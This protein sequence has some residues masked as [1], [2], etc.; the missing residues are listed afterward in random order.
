MRE[1]PFVFAACD[2]ALAGGA[3]SVVPGTKTSSGLALCQEMSSGVEEGG[4]EKRGASSS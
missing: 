3:A 1:V 4:R 2:G